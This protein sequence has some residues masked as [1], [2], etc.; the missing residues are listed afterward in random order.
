MG[1]LPVLPSENAC[2]FSSGRVPM[3]YI[4]FNRTMSPCLDTIE[5]SHGHLNSIPSVAFQEMGLTSR[6]YS[7]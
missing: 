3:L 5:L 7:L 4:R 2:P 6:V 1:H